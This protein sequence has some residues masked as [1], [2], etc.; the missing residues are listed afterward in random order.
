MRQIPSHTASKLTKF[1]TGG[2]DFFSLRM[3]EDINF[4]SYNAETKAFAEIYKWKLPVENGKYVFYDQKA[5]MCIT[6][7]KTP[8]PHTW[9]SAASSFQPSK[10]R[11]FQMRTT[12]E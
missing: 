5:T 12:E 8:P 10:M 11:T 7:S 4:F 6:P 3:G 1:E 9:I 2:Q